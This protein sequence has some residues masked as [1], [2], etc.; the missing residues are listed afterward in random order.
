[1]IKSGRMLLKSGVIICH[2]RVA[3][4]ACLSK[5]AEVGQLEPRGKFGALCFSR[6]LQEISMHGQKQNQQQCGGR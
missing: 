1:M 6:F 5:E 3:G 2:G 4:I